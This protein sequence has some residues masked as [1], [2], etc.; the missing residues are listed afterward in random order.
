MAALAE[1]GGYR[2]AAFVSTI[3]LSKNNC[4]LA[5]GFQTYDDQT[6][7]AELNRPAFLYRRAL[8]TEKAA[9]AWLEAHGRRPF[10]LWVH[11]MD[12]HGPYCPPAPHDRRFNSDSR[13]LTPFDRLHLPLVPDPRFSDREPPGYLPG[14]PSYQA[15]GLDGG[16]GGREGYASS[17][18]FYLD[19]YDGAVS[20]VDLACGRIIS[21]L[22]KQG[23]F[24][25]TTIV[26]HS[27]HGE[28][29]GEEGVFF[30]HG[31]SLTPDQIRIPLIVK[32]ASLKQG[33]REDPVSLCD[34]TPFLLQEMGL[35]PSE[36]A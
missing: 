30:F 10:F 4:G 11:F 26:V 36:S 7:R 20:Y 13:P 35:A 32:S 9:S 16:P 31:L 33:P 23:L 18:R 29:L 6:P 1:E 25:D 17:F 8:E 14:I 19:R 12:V 2:T 24:E 34:L 3:V 22:K 27:D 21:R 28:A 5:Q 15:L